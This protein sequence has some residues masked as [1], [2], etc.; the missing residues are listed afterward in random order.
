MAGHFITQCSCGKVLGQCRCPGP[1]KDIK[2]IDRGCEACHSMVNVLYNN[3]DK[4][5]TIT[6]SNGDS[7]T[8]TP[9]QWAFVRKTIDG[10]YNGPSCG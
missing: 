7:I 10:L 1:N 2:I 3:T 6:D 9:E 8:L 4:H 5:W